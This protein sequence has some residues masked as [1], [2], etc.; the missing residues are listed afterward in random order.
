MAHGGRRVEVKQQ[1]DTTA[2]RTGLGGKGERWRN[3]DLE[4][5][6]T[7]VCIDIVLRVVKHPLRGV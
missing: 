3:P 6:T 1:R 2:A 4:N 5:T 7:K